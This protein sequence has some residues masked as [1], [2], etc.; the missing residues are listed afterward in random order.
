LNVT[1]KTYRFYEFCS[2]NKEM[3]MI[4]KN[5]SDDKKKIM[6]IKKKQ[7][8]IEKHKSYKKFNRIVYCFSK[9]MILMQVHK[10]VINVKCIINN[11]IEKEFNRFCEH[12]F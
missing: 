7:K 6:K 2:D 12:K 10:C 4:K 9:N 5:C 8:R 3:M 11:I 1:G